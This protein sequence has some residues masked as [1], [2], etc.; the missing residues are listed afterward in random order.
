MLISI[1]LPDYDKSKEK[2]YIKYLDMNNLY[3]KAMSEYLPYG[4]FKW[5]KVNNE[6]VNR[7]LNKTGNS[8][9]GYFLEVDLEVPE[10]L[11]DKHNDLLM[12]PE[13]IKVT[14]KMLS[15]F[16]LEIKK[17]MILK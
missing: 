2:V 3:G 17:N 4:G 6:V 11:H 10:K 12:G 1:F 13:K 16:Q 8:L 9:H 14:D 15:P 5:V 7:I